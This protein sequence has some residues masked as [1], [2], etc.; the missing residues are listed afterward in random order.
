VKIAIVC[1]APSSCDLAPFAE[2]EWEIWVLG[3]RLDRHAGRRV[4]RIFEIH[5]DLSEHGDA[6]AYARWLVA[7]KIPMTVGA[8]FPV[9]AEHVETFPFKASH[10]L[11]GAEYLTS[12][13]AYMMALAILK[14]ATEIGVYGSDMS[15][16]DHEYFWQRP[17]LEAWVGFAKGR[18]IK[19]TIPPVS[20]VGKSTYVE[21]RNG[22]GK[23]D[24]AKPPFTEHA[25]R[26]LAQMH[27][28]KV[29]E[30]EA[31]IKQLEDS[32]RIHSGALQAYERMA[33]VARAV[34]AGIEVSL[35]ET[36]VLK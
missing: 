30:K 10:E 11:Y 18:G 4:S 2:P 7:Q 14:G 21:G 28:Q 22:G 24:F 25:F 32:I 9:T 8:S 6:L 31:Q 12:S 26:E 27:S 3:N 35:T 34:E 15:V 23:P 29:A 20:P 1:G 33:K 16:D 19:V 5:D 17:C 36:V 13:T